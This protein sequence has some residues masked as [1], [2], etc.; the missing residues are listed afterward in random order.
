MTKIE[1]LLED[2]IL[3][4]VEEIETRQHI[5]LTGLN[6]GLT[7]KVKHTACEC[8]APAWIDA[9]QKDRTVAD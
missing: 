3:A 9:E 8:V 5:L 6:K 4:V 2:K 1:N 7:N